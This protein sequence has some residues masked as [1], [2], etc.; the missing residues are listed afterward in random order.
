M[1]VM[2][3]S[4]TRTLGGLLMWFAALGGAL[5]W[6]VHLLAAWSI[7]ELTCAAGNRQVSGVP[8]ETVL[9]LTVVIPAAV[10]LV[11]WLVSC[12]AWRR[13][14]ARAGENS[15]RAAEDDAPRWERAQLVAMVGLWSNP[16]FLA[17]IVAGG[18]SILVFA[19]CQL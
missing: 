6:T 10:A 19:P 4:G 18:A 12:R 2:A 3:S 14:S 8:L 15:A 1:T 17:I 7:A 5:A 16:L 13:V 11:A 9:A